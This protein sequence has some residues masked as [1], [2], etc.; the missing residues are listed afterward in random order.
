MQTIIKQLNHIDNDIQRL[1]VNDDELAGW[2]R[3]RVTKRLML[4]LEYAML[5]ALLPR[6]DGP[7][8][9]IDEAALE[10]SYK[11]ALAEAFDMI[12]E[13]KPSDLLED[14]E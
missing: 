8:E 14:Q 4:E 13:W 10:L 5:L 12:I 9:K 7:L 6:Y 3:H 1:A 11:K 2:R